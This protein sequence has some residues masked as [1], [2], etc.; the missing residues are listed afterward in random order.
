MRLPRALSATKLP[1]SKSCGYYFIGTKSHI[2]ESFFALVI[3]TGSWGIC[4]EPA[5]APLRPTLARQ[6][7]GNPSSLKN[8]CQLACPSPSRLTLPA[9]LKRQQNEP[10][11]I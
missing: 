9:V 7:V 4:L 10:T 11:S 8:L 2:Y 1:S 3:L 6:K 5:R